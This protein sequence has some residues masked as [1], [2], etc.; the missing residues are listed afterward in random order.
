MNALERFGAVIIKEA[1]QMIRDKRSLAF[2]I[3]LPL[4]I[5]TLFGL[6]YS[7]EA[8]DVVIGIVDSDHGEYGD[9]LIQHFLSH[10]VFIVKYTLPDYETGEYYVEEGYVRAVIVIPSTFSESIKSQQTSYIVVILDG[11]S[12]TLP[13]KIVEETQKILQD[14]S[15]DVFRKSAAEEKF[16]YPQVDTVIKYVPSS[17]KIIDVIGPVVMGI[18]TQQVP[19]TLASLSIV[20]EREKGTL[21]KLLSTPITKYDLIFGKLVPYC[22]VGVLIGILQLTITIAL[23]GMNRG[24][25]VDIIIVLFFLSLASLALGIFISIVSRTELQAVQVSVFFL[26]ASF[27]FS[28]FLFPPEM[29]KSFVRPIIYGMPLY[30]FFLAIVDVMIR[31]KTIIEVGIPIFLLGIYAIIMLVLALKFLSARIG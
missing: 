11:T 14:F 16:L 17:L 25:V 28:G 5:I 9:L 18:M 27:L 20:R 4:A 24:R 23:G 30:Y 22:F 10:P 13:S 1:K 19:L 15:K 26:I 6:A 7:G 21:E 3:V 12:I 8:T 29:M 2:T 31:G